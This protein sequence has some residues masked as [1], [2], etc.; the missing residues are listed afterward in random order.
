MPVPFA[1]SEG[2]HAQVVQPDE[3]VP[4]QMARDVRSQPAAEAPSAAPAPAAKDSDRRS[5]FMK[6][7]DAPRADKQSFTFLLGGSPLTVEADSVRVK[8]DER[9]RMLVI[10]TQQGIIRLRLSGN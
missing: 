5:R 9:G 1:S 2:K 8:E 6:L 3:E 10:Y 4:A 7:D